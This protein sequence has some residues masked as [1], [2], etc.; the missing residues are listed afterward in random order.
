MMD[1]PRSA[2]A[3]DALRDSNALLRAVTEGTDDWV[4][5]KDRDG[6]LLLVNPAVCKAFGKPS[7]ELIGKTLAEYVPNPEEAE[8]I[9]N[10]DR[11]VME[12]RCTQ[13][14]EQRI[15]IDGVARTQLATKTPRF[16]AAGNVIG[17]IGISTD[18]TDRKKAEQALEM[19]NEA[20]AATVA[21]KTAGLTEL[22]QHLMRI[23]EDEKAKLA[24]ELHDELGSLVT[25]IV[26]DAELVLKDLPATSPKLVERQKA[27][28]ELARRAAQLKRRIIEGLRPLLLEQFGLVPALRDHLRQW[29]ATTGIAPKEYFREDLVGLDQDAALALY[30]V[31]Q[32]SLTNIARHARAKHVLV[33]LDQTAAGIVLVIEDDGIGIARETLQRPTSHGIFGMRQRIAGFSGTL[34]VEPGA[35]GKGTRITV[36]L[37]LD[38]E[39]G[40]PRI[41][42]S[43]TAVRGSTGM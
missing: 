16:D 35:K 20:L 30:R 3:E 24:A 6:R 42:S 31:A 19:A 15:T 34:T 11:R 2:D 37:P 21:E 40:M 17:L 22:T 28:I 36:H 27:I 1:R 32:E 23:A 10:N 9:R 13:R 14:F 5:V 7:E 33:K 12:S 8:A 25:A 26:L 41:S 43:E 29:K 39:T 4:Y 18:I 38:R